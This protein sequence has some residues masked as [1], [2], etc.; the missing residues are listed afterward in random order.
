ML[1][2]WVRCDTAARPMAEMGQKRPKDDVHVKSGLPPTADIDRRG[3]HV[4]SVPLPE[5]HASVARLRGCRSGKTYFSS[6]RIVE[7]IARLSW[8][9][10]IA[11]PTQAQAPTSSKTRRNG[12][13]GVRHMVRYVSRKGSH[14]TNWSIFEFCTLIGIAGMG[15]IATIS[16]WGLLLWLAVTLPHG[17]LLA[18]RPSPGSWDC[19]AL[20]P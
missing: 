8:A 20:A 9:S 17:Q 16:W 4:G 10:M 18:S 5:L 11:W 12:G 2:Y 6:F 15:V 3:W 7:Q 19:R 1:A 13:S 14:V